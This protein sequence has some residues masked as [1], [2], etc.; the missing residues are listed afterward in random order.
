MFP[1][2]RFLTGLIILAGLSL[3]QSLTPT[4]T[5]TQQVLPLPGKAPVELLTNTSFEINT[6]GDK[7]PDGWKGKHTSSVKSDKQI[8]NKPQKTVAHTGN[9]AF[10]FR[11][12]TSGTT[13]KL[14]QTLTATSTLTEGSTV[15]FSAYIDPRS[16]EPGSI[17]GQTVISLSNDSKI[18]LKLMIPATPAA[19]D[20]PDPVVFNSKIA[21]TVAAIVDYQQI[22]DSETLTL[23]GA[24]ITK[25]KT[26]FRY[27]ETNGKFYIDDSSL[28]SEA[29]APE[30]PSIKL[31]ASDGEAGDYFS[32]AVAIDG[33][34][35]VV[36]SFLDDVGDNHWQGSAYVF[37]R[38]G[39]TWLQ[40]QQLI[41]SDGAADDLFGNAVA[42]DGDTIIV[43]SWNDNVN[44]HPYQG[45]AYIF[46]RSGNTWTEQQ[47]L[48]LDDGAENDVFGVA[49]ALQ[50]DTALVSAPDKDTV[51]T[52]TRSDGSWTQQQTLVPDDVE[53]HKYFGEDIAI[54]GNT[55]AVASEYYDVDNDPTYGAVYVYTTDG[56]TWTQQQELTESVEPD[57]NTFARSLDLEENTLVVGSDYDNNQRGSAYVFTRAG[58]TWTEQQR[59]IASD[60]AA[61][62]GFGWSVSIAG[63][64]LVIGALI[65]KVGSNIFQGS[66]YVFTYDGA[67]WIE[68]EHLTAS[69]GEE[70]DEFG[71]SMSM[72]GNTVVIGAIIDDI[73][74]HIDQG[75]AYV[76]DLP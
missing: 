19:L 10:M 21:P 34:T 26:S 11:G 47:K 3:G 71:W 60:G 75:S 5:L 52:F 40:Q 9:C 55:V 37:I 48:I 12:N 68:Q 6:N 64:H 49:V 27:G 58:D 4:T 28:L 65:D 30:I 51:Y 43:A 46:T 62:D 24:A 56:T 50:G 1:K 29:T 25:V 7:L 32:K 13:S 39:D 70:G 76:F 35:L 17:F 36:G 72:S 8:C 54:S 61:L 33:D 38:S 42:I 2:M 22:E 57:H 74:G 73:D 23:N 31:T 14:E 20:L 63:N 69:D 66:A 15:T 53:T 44:G 59:L 41:A 67:A 18:K 16:A 45:S